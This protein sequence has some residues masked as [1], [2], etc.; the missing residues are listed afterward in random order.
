MGIPLAA[1][2]TLKYLIAN[3][4]NEIQ[5]QQA[6]QTVKEIAIEENTVAEFSTWLAG[7]NMANLPDIQ[8]EKA[9]FDAIERLLINGKKKALKKALK[10]TCKNYPQGGNLLRA[11]FLLAEMA[12]EQEDWGEAVGLTNTWSLPVQ[13][14]IP[15]KPW[16]A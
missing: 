8:L 14:N 13:M 6:L 15:N 1:N 10:N 7:V 16:C 11:Q 2:T 4:P 3:Y 5:A 12:F 9:A